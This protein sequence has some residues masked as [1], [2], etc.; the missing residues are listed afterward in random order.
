MANL[1]SG[2]RFAYFVN[3]ALRSMVP[4]R[5]V[6]NIHDGVVNLRSWIDRNRFEVVFDLSSHQLSKIDLYSIDE[7]IS[8]AD[9]IVASN[10]FSDMGKAEVENSISIMNLAKLGFIA[11]IPTIDHFDIKPKFVMNQKQWRQTLKKVGSVVSMH[12]CED[13]EIFLVLK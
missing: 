13:Y 11:S 5:Y 3:H 6:G 9:F 12:Q 10:P 7:S 2:L 1:N 4:A 8:S